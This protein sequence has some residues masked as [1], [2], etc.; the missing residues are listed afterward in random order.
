MCQCHTFCGICDQIS[1]NERIFH[2]DMSHCDTVTDCD[3]R[4]YDRNTACFRYAKFYGVYDLI[5]IHM[6]RNDLIVRAYNTDHRLF[7]FLFGKA[8]CIEQTSVWSLLHS[9]FYIITSH[10]VLSFYILSQIRSPISFVPT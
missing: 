10:S 3:R 1:C 6:P 5:Q 4:K 2:T 8:K 9:L 7:H